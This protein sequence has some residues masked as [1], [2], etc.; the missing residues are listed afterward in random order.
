[1]TEQR[2]R[3]GCCAPSAGRRGARPQP[4]APASGAGATSPDGLVLLPGGDF[5]MGSADEHAYPQDGEGPVRRVGLAPF[6]ISPTAVTN[7][8]FAA[9]AGAT[10]YRTDAERFGW[11]FVFAGLLPDDF[12]PTRGVAAAP[13]WRQVE[14]ASWRR[15]A[16]PRSDLDGLADHPVVHVSWNDAEAYCAWAGLRL[17]TEAE[18]EFAARG[19]LTGCAYPWGDEREPGGQ[20]RMNV[21]QGAFPRE[22][23]RDDGWYGTCPVGAFPPNGFGL[24]NMTGNVWEWCRDRFSPGPRRG[25][26]ARAAAER[27]EVRAAAERVEVR[28]AAEREDARA[29]AEREDPRPPRAP[30]QGIRRSARGGSYLCHDSYCRRYRVSARQGIAPDSSMGNTGFRCARDA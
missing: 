16:G 14:D 12:P 28:A 17:P 21:W 25:G 11:S 2:P 4:A 15:P 22:N 13:W 3:G 7:A 5:L 29:A 27:V 24:H 10:G 18:W 26:P 1:M 9:F 8:E 6:R 20:H 23:T 19:G 30:E